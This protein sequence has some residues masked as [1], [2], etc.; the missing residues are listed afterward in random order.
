MHHVTVPPPPEHLVFMN[1]TAQQGIAQGKR[2]VLRLNKLGIN[3]RDGLI[4]DIGCGWGRLAYGLHSFGFDGV[5]VGMDITPE[6]IGWLNENFA[7]INPRYRFV[8]EDVQNELY[9]PNGTKKEADYAGILEGCKADTIILLSVMT[10]LYEQE[11]YSHLRRINEAMHPTSKL[12]FSCFILDGPAEKTIAEGKASKTFPH[13]LSSYCRISS[14]AKPLAAIGYTT[15]F[16]ERALKDNG[17]SGKFLHGAWSGGRQG[18]GQDI[19]ICQTQ[20]SD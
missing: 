3:V 12:V 2:Q 8:H 9:N 7:P 20:M 5:Y 17:M 19:F 6:R 10:H 14:K 11:I 15:G 18:M 13:S 4:L 1:A 16:F